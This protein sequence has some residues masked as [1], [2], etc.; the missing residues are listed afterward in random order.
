MNAQNLFSSSTKS[1]ELLLSEDTTG[2]TSDSGTETQC[3]I[4]DRDKVQAVSFI[5]LHMVVVIC[6]ISSS[7]S[8]HREDLRILCD[9]RGS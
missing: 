3:N 8:V 7:C 5:A 2:S 9:S 6:L 1:E 4:M